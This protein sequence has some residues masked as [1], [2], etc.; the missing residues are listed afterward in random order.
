MIFNTKIFKNINNLFFK[1]SSFFKRLYSIIDFRHYIIN[2]TDLIFI[3][4]NFKKKSNIIFKNGFIF[5]NFRKKNWRYLHFYLIVF[6]NKIKVENVGD[7]IIAKVNSFN[8]KLLDSINGIYQIKEVFV[9]N[10]YDKFDYTNKVIIDIGGYIG[11]TA[12]YFISK[13]AKKVQVYEVNEEVYKILLENIKLNHLEDKVIAFNKGVSND[14]NKKILNITEIK[15]SSGFYEN[16]SKLMNIIDRKEIELIPVKD[17][18]KEQIDIL[19]IDCEGCEYEILE[20]ILENNLID[21]IN[22]GIILESHYLDD[23]RNSVYIKALLGKLGFK[24]IFYEKKNR[25]TGLI[26]GIKI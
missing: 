2:W 23:K 21:K 10:S 14:Y 8:L 17:V 12:L 15:G 13:G 24:K 22:E 16:Y 26:Y 1:K 9:Q 4:L 18:L 11:D 3:S 19:K 6:K 20:N 25:F 7:K 5:R